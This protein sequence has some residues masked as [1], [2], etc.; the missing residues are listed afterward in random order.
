MIVKKF[1]KSKMQ[2]GFLHISLKQ[3]DSRSGESSD[4][5][6]LLSSSFS[7]KGGDSSSSENSSRTGRVGFIF[8]QVRKFSLKR[9]DSC[10]S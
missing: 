8:V 1:R 6:D 3:E 5:L 4:D 2:L 10:S 7:L 9:G